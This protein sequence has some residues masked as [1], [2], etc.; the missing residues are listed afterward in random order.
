MYLYIDCEWNHKMIEE[1]SHDELISMALC[2][3]NGNEFYEVLEW[4]QV[5]DWVR[6]NVIP[7]LDKEPVT[8]E[9]F[10]QKL[11]GF[12]LQY[13]RFHIVADWPLDLAQFC[14]ILVLG[15]KEVMRI[16]PFSMQVV[17]VPIRS[18][19]PHNALCDARAL[20][21]SVDALKV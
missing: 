10:Q 1:T 18:E 6:R 4:S 9:V 17:D 2:D 12:L 11:R 20:K 3:E 5:N 21:K 13:N 16:P 7:V 8:R 19:K 14:N 15:P